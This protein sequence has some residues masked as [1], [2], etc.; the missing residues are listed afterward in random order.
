MVLETATKSNG[1]A[2]SPGIVTASSGIVTYY[3]DGSNLTGLT[4]ASAST[5]G[6]ANTT[7]V[8]TVDSNGRITGI[9]TV[10]PPQVLVLVVEGEEDHKI[11]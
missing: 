6:D 3:G 10:L 8:I 9:S 1:I 5:Y 11:L 2:V 7:P 4:G